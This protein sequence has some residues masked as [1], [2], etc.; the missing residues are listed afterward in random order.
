M[1]MVIIMRPDANAD[2]INEVISAVEEMGL[3]AKVME[4]ESQKIV[5]VIGDKA[6][7]CCLNVESFKGVE[8]TVNISKS[9]KLVSREFHPQST[10][11]DVDGIKI[12]DGSL[13]VMA[14]PCAV[15][16]KEQ[17]LEAARI[18]KAGGAQFIRGGAYKPRTSP[19]SFQGL[20]ELGL[21]YLAAAREATGLKV[22]TE[23]TEVDA[24]PVVAEYADILQIGARN[25]QNFRLLKEV[26]RIDKP[27]M[28]KRGLS[29]TLDEW[30]NAAEYIMSEGNSKVIFCERGIRTYE[31]YTRNTLDLSAVA[32]IKHLSH[33]PIVV[34]PSHGTGKWRMIKPMSY[35]AVAAGADGLIIEMHPNP[36]K[37]LSD[38]PQ[39]LTPDSYMDLMQGV[40]KLAGFM[41][42]SGLAIREL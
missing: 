10:V 34:D 16:S 32:A 27:V 2:S 9:Y 38:G 8:K 30:L 7:M 6:K 13:V 23:V 21:K 5:G 11:I 22:V 24:V 12:G 28:L 35:A 37:A 4:G 19:Y 20:E 3:T 42:E 26:G 15:E 31:T 18:A 17:L 41:Q 14:G 29:A 36:A 25:M 1:R 40:Q 33:L 39:S